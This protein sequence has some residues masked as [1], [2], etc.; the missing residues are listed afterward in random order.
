M[1]C[2]S[3]FY[4]E[5]VTVV[6]IPCNG[7]VECSDGS[8]EPWVCHNTDFILYGVGLFC[9][10]IIALFVVMKYRS[11]RRDKKI[12]V[13]S[14][15]KCLAYN[16]KEWHCNKLFSKLSQY[17]AM[18]DVQTLKKIL[19]TVT[20]AEKKVHGS[21]EHQIML[22]LKNRYTKFEISI[23]MD[24]LHPSFL[25]KYLPF[26][27]IFDSFSDKYQLFWWF[28]HKVMT[29]LFVYIDISKD[30]LITFTLLFL[31]GGLQTLIEFPTVF[32]SAVVISLLASIFVPLFLSS[33]QLARHNPDM[34]FGE[35]FYKLPRWKQNLGKLGI[36]LMCLINPA[37]LV[38][39][40]ESNQ[41]KLRFQSL[42]KESYEE[43]EKIIKRGEEIQRQYVRY[44]RT[45]LGF[46]VI[47]QIAGQI[48]LLLQSSTATPTVS[49]LEVMFGKSDSYG[50]P[51]EVIVTV[52][53]IWSFKTCITLPLKAI[54]VEKTHVEFKAKAFLVLISLFSAS[55][56][57]LSIVSYFTPFMG[58][59]DLLHHHELE[60][61]PFTVSL[62][63][64]LRP[65]DM[66]EMY[67]TTPVRWGLVDRWDYS[68]PEDPTPPPYTLYTLLRLGESLQLFFIILV[69]HVLA[70]MMVK[71]FHADKFGEADKLD[72]FIHVVENLTIAYPFQDFDVL[73]GS[74]REHRER[75]D[76]VNREVGLTMAV[77]FVFH[78][79]MLLPLWYTGSQIRSRHSLLQATIGVREEEVLSYNTATNLQAGMTSAVVLA[80]LLGALA[81]LLYNYKV[82][83]R[84]HGE[85]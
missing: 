43:V 1:R 7:I 10:L 40:Y 36:V 49:G 57:L 85:S 32:T 67:N 31:I 59:F 52:S 61:L 19:K 29:V 63:G 8:D 12:V 6:A 60:Q 54:E 84:S 45:E 42:T 38:L 51:A 21:N 50:I 41:E 81:F 53:I 26:L 35:N 34:I 80:S 20:E 28:L 9:L 16:M 39:A 3:I 46:E 64:K 78:L 75:F 17:L 66:L 30:L 22:C 65:Y 47:F 23:I 44:I 37:L 11:L 33:L 15:P 79:V 83:D 58:L 73:H 24:Y 25:K 48:L 2:Q 56:R 5:L 18:L 82:T 68:D 76:K 74:A 69:L 71:V 70:V 72:R 13:S 4:P 14:F 27:K 77:N 55:A 62:E